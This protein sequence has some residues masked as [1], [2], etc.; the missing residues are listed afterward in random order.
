MSLTEIK[1][2]PNAGLVAHIEQLLEMAKSG[3]MQGI[4]EVVLL[5]D[6]SAGCG[7]NLEH[8]WKSAKVI[9]ELF[10]LMTTLANAAE[11]I[12]GDVKSIKEILGVPE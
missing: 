11:G 4:A 5:D 10:T 12:L 1:T 7:W 3:R 2:Q 6:D 9:G 8:D